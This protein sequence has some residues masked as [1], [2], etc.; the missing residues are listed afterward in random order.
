MCGIYLSLD[1]LVNL[2]KLADVHH[3]INRACDHDTQQV[4][5]WIETGQAR[6]QEYAASLQRRQERLCYLR[7]EDEGRLI[8]QS[9]GKLKNEINVLNQKLIEA[10]EEEEAAR[11]VNNIKLHAACLIL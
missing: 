4:A 10:A 9:V 11:K 3:R 8:E 5:H 6:E 7:G 2:C 1:G